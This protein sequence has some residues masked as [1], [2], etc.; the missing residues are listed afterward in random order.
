MSNPLTDA[1]HVDAFAEGSLSS[2]ALQA[3]ED[4]EA[5][6]SATDASDTPFHA[7]SGLPPRR[8][9]QDLSAAV[10]RV[11]AWHRARSLHH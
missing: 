8:A 2:A 7:R 3:P 9:T 1:A 10:Q 4:A 11:L 6:R 5:D